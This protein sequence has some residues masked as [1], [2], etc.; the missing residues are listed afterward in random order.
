M[1]SVI[2]AAETAVAAIVFCLAVYFFII[3]A[4]N[5]DKYVEEAFKFGMEIEH[6][7]YLEY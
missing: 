2:E 7:S 6:C 5:T 1:D 3:L 4:G